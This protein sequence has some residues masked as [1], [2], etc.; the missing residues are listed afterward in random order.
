MKKIIT[1]LLCLVLALGLFA[2]CGS[3][4][5]Q[6]QQELNLYTWDGL[7]PEEVLADFTKETGIKINY[8]SFDSNE[9]MLAKLEAA[10]GGD[11][12]LVVADDYIIETAVNE[13]LVMELDKEKL[14]GYGNIN[15]LYQ[16]HYFDP[17]N[18][19]AVPYGAGV[20][21]ILYD[22]E[23]VSIEIDSFDDLTD[24][25]LKD[26]IG[27]SDNARVIHGMSLIADGES[28]NAED[29][30]AIEKAAAQVME[31]APNIR[32]IKENGLHE[33][34]VSGEISVALTYN[35]EV[36]QACMAKPG[37]KVV[38][39]TEGVGFGIMAQF[40]P[41]NAPHPDA[42]HA[43]IDYILQPEVSKTCFENVGYYSTNKAA[44]ALIAEEMRPFL[45][46]PDSLK[47]E[48]MDM[49][50]NISA[51]SLDLHSKYWTE[52][53]TACGQ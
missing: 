50:R 18:K 9:A 29:P 1:L 26:S 2:G 40:I 52:F 28:V 15:P 20:Q 35:S 31:M 49:M 39:P 33:D 24:P 4:T 27:V 41:V 38:Y 10:K 11:Y 47:V 6:P 21:T 3:T 53:R 43:F 42:A 25:S 19:Y 16:G 45:T 32:L 13:G 30:A 17:E 34:I 7:F 22:P 46:L 12:D 8:S 44:D 37:L 36:T 5:D 51:E 14:T 48:Q 23:K